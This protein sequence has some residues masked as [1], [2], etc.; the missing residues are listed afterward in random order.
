VVLVEPAMTDTD[1]WRNAPQT[2]EDE[3]AAMSAEHRELYAEHL[4][5]MRRTIPRIQKMAKPVDTVTAAIERALTAGRPK[6]RYQVG[7]D[8]KAQAALTAV[9]PSRVLDAM[10]G[11]LT[12]MPPK[13]KR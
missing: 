2:L 11:K 1:L 5:G 10:N 4:E 6:A 12:G 8:V 13:P 3:T 7:I 9:T